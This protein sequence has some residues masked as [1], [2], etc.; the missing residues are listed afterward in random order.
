M[1]ER[2]EKPTAKETAANASANARNEPVFS[3]ESLQK[4]CKKLF[5]VST[6]TFVGATH[7]IEQRG[8]TVEEVKNIITKW[9]RQEVE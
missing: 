4:H 8:Y 5:G 3:L 7:G 6:V 9:C 2:K 1:A